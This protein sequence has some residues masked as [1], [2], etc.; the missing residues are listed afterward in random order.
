[1]AAKKSDY[2]LSK[3]TFI[4]GVQCEKSL[5]LHKH[6]P[7]L[8]DRISEI[9]RAK[10]SRGSYIGQLAQS[11]FPGGRDASPPTH[12]QMKK[13]VE[14]TRLWMDEGVEVIY[15]A[16]FEHRGVVIALDILQKTDGGWRAYEVKSSRELSDTYLWDASLQWWVMK[17]AG[18]L[19]EAFVLVH[20]NPDY[21]LEDVQDVE[22]LFMK[23]DVTAVVTE[24]GDMVGGKVESFQK[25]LELKNSPQLPIGLHCNYPYPCDFIGHCWKKAG[26]DDVLFLPGVNEKERFELHH[27]GVAI[28]EAPSAITLAAIE[29]RR[30]S[31]PMVW[32][33]LKKHFECMLNGDFYF[34]NYV[35]TAPG[36]PLFKHT[37]PFEKIPVAANLM[38]F[39]HGSLEESLSWEMPKEAG[40]AESF[41]SFIST[42]CATR[43]PLY[44]FEKGQLCELMTRFSL[45][46]EENGNLKYLSENLYSVFDWFDNEWMLS[47]FAVDTS[48]VVAFYKSLG[49]VA[50]K[51]KMPFRVEASFQYWM[52]SID[53]NYEFKVDIDP[54]KIVNNESGLVVGFL[55]WLSVVYGN[56]GWFERN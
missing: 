33:G 51:E 24:R 23:A 36:V 8:R 48:D 27:K 2:W 28:P 43:L 7:F 37:R 31:I 32:D 30:Q 53:S 16:A 29:G 52:K 34:L 49:L 44:T 14:Q 40:D 15:E 47:D 38:K 17:G 12:F 25:V 54:A 11:L 20:I 45:G 13:S 6:R 9:Q 35:W 18:V 42:I 22:S 46:T 1:M 56:C 39:K 10:F 26:P 41:L 3:S 19:L 55:N 4:R 50:E 21:V 5:Y